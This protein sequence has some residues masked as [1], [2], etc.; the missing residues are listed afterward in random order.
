VWLLVVVV[1]AVGCWLASAAVFSWLV[2]IKVLTYRPQEQ[3][4]GREASRHLMLA[5]SIEGFRQLSQPGEVG[6]HGLLTALALAY[7]SGN[8]LASSNLAG[9]LVAHIKA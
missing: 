3:T 1:D 4:K 6:F 9:P 7:G 2:P 8:N 5:A